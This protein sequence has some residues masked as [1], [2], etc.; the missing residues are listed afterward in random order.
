MA[1]ENVAFSDLAAF[2]SGEVPFRNIIDVDQIETGI[3]ESGAVITRDPL[4]RVA[5]VEWAT[6][7]DRTNFEY[8]MMRIT[9]TPSDPTTISTTF[10]TVSCDG[11]LLWGAVTTLWDGI[12]ALARPR[13]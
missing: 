10:V 8:Q 11:V 3:E 1:A 13:S 12:N 6:M 2:E 4:V 5:P 9:S 7:R